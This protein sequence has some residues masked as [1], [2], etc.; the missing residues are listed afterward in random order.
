DLDLDLTVGERGDQ[1]L[2]RAHAQFAADARSQALVGIAGEDEQ[3]AIFL[4]LLH[5][6]R[7]LQSVGGWKATNWAWWSAAP[8]RGARERPRASLA[9]AAGFEP[10]NAGIKTRCL[11]PLGD[12]PG[13][14]HMR[15]RQCGPQR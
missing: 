4:H 7:Q 2:A 9:G 13:L 5:F 6:R 15:T 11:G 10:A 3:V 12:A 1:R 8:W 14:L